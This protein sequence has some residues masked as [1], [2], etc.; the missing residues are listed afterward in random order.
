MKI[1]TISQLDP[2]TNIKEESLFEVSEPK[3]DG[4]YTSKNLKFTDL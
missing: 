1:R 3:A 2:V 4:K